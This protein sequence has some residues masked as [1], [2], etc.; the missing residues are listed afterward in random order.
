[1]SESEDRGENQENENN[2]VNY[3][4]NILKTMIFHKGVPCEKLKCSL[5]LLI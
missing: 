4:V 3:S 5:S 2:K 1:M